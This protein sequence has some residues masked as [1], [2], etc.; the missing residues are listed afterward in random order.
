MADR[1]GTILAGGEGKRLLPLTYVTNKSLLPVF[2]KP[3]ITYPL[4]TLKRS[5]VDN[6][7]IV[8]GE[9]HLEDFIRFLE[10]YVRPTLTFTYRVQSKPHGTAHALLQ[11]EGFF[12]EDKV[13]VVLADNVFGDATVPDS[14]FT[15][16]YAYIFVKENSNPSLFGVVE[17]DSEGN[18]ISIE[19]K[20]ESPKSNLVL[21]GMYV[22]PNDVFRRIRQL[23]E[24]L[25][26]ELELTDIIKEYMQEGLLKVV[27]V[28]G[29]WSDVGSFDSLLK[30]SEYYS[31]LGKD[32]TGG[33]H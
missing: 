33:K 31:K 7:C 29:F 32:V 12:G 17:I 1:K 8:T 4:D 2:D 16:K 23:K 30:A 10:I 28:D 13:V 6:V 3:M 25:R 11:S 26:G 5:G 20:P 21:T 14:A 27:R 22:Y 15:D 19:E 24:S 18:A 9:D